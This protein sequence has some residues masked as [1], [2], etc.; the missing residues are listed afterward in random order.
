MSIEGS[1]ASVFR[2]C[3][4]FCPVDAPATIMNGLLSSVVDSADVLADV[5]IEGAAP[6]D[7][8]DLATA[9]LPV[10]DFTAAS[11]SVVAIA[12]TQKQAVDTTVSRHSRSRTRR[13]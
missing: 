1:K 4:F 9:P 7:V 12:A 8:V 6:A 11:A 13:S 10:A 3:A 2:R 5:V